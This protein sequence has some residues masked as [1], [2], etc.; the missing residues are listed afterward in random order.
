MVSRKTLDELLVEI[1]RRRSVFTRAWTSEILDRIAR[2]LSQRFQLEE[3][4]VRSLIREE[5]GERGGPAP[6]H[7]P[8]RT[9]SDL[10]AVNE[11]PQS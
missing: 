7:K 5:L 6:T 3:A 2:E 8:T 10:A 1:R 11:D 4:L 9:R